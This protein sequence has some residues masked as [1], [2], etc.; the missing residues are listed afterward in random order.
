[1]KLAELKP[2]FD[3]DDIQFILE[4]FEEL[5]SGDGYLTMGKYC[6]QFENGFAEY[7]DNKYAISCN[8]GTAALEMICRS[9]NIDGKE[10]IL[11]TNTFIATA[12]AIINAGGTPVFAD[13]KDDMQLDPEDVIRKI[14]NNTKAVM[15]VHIGGYVSPNIVD[16][17]SICKDNNI[18]LFEDAA[19]A[20]GTYYNG[21]MAGTFGIG[22]GFSF[23][24]TKVMTTGEGGMVSTNDNY[25]Y[26]QS[27]LLRQYGKVPFSIYQ[28]YSEILGYNWRMTEVC[29]LMGIR[30]LDK[31][32]LFIKRRTEIAKIYNDK[33]KNIPNMEFM[34]VNDDV[35][36]NWFKYIIYLKGIDRE[37]FH[38]KLKNDYNINLSGYVYEIPLHKQPALK[39]F[40]TND[41]YPVAN[42]ICSSHIC[43]PLFYSLSDDEV[44]Y[45]I[46]SLKKCLATLA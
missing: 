46:D 1:M 14:T 31:L 10:V 22:G 29:A 38:L 30:Q 28:N 4:N 20:H 45:I 21:K 12:N 18:L 3:K 6:K 26:E 32:E 23:F 37:K 39:S 5:L 40:I 11:P 42:E 7:Q 16:L 2:F 43:L 9:M 13:I 44:N 34:P 19:Q 17:V 35:R 8:S 15:T 41:N 25:L 36:F 27:K 33:L 24:S